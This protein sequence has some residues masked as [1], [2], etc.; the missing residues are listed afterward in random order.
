MKVDAAGRE[1]I[2]YEEGLRLRAYRDSGGVWTI[3]LGTTRY[4]DGRPVRKGDTCTREEAL[5]WMEH[6]LAWAEDAVNE[7]VKVP[8]N[9]PM[10]NALVSM[11]YN[12]GKPR[13]MGSTLVKLL[14]GG[15]Y[16]EAQKEFDKWVYV[17]GEKDEKVLVKRRDRE[18]KMFNDGIRLALGGQ[19]EILADFN[20]AVGEA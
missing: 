6:D 14:N 20:D 17:Q 2:S 12:I 11:A 7:S 1:A 9:Q 5:A 3:G 16:T 13:F 15:W 4:P 10:F 19:P 8:L 18:Q